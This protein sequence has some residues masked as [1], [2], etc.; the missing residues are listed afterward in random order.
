MEL[1]EHLLVL[2]LAKEVLEEAQLCTER[3]WVGLLTFVSGGHGFL[4]VLAVLLLLQRLDLID[5]D[6]DGPYL[7]PQGLALAAVD[8]RRGAL[9][10]HGAF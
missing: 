10:A 8:G 6:D 1:L 4:A 9:P 7:L 5:E 2:V 3:H